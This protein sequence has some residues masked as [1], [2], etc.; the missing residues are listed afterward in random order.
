MHDLDA[1]GGVSSREP[2]LKLYILPRRRDLRAQVLG[3]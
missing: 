3:D 2:G 1:D